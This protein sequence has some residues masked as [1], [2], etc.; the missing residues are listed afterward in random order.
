MQNHYLTEPRLD[1]KNAWDDITD[2]RILL[3]G[4]THGLLSHAEQ[5]GQQK[6]VKL[7]V[8]LARN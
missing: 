7:H 3:S 2:G 4:Q 6:F 8:K 5:K 1:F